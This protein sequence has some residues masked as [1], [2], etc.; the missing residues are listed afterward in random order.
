MPESYKDVVAQCID[1]KNGDCP[2][3]CELH[4]TSLIMTRRNRPNYMLGREADVEH[5]KRKCEKSSFFV[6]EST[7]AIALDKA[8]VD[9]GDRI[10]LDRASAYLK[11]GFRV[12]SPVPHGFVDSVARVVTRNGNYLYFV[13]S[14]YLSM[15]VGL[16]EN[17]NEPF[18]G[19]FATYEVEIE[20]RAIMSPGK[21]SPI[22][23]AWKFSAS[24]SF[25]RVERSFTVN[26]GSGG[27]QNEE[28]FLNG[29]NASTVD[30]ED[31]RAILTTTTEILRGNT[32]FKP[33]V[34]WIANNAPEAGL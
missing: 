2:K 20:R 10:V 8:Q 34:T 33:K 1:P 22:K 29:F 31:T 27:D 15:S 18:A 32:A 23:E 19:G 24:S 9:P 6:P 14:S 26:P 7:I 17:G 21:N 11:Q 5:L 13:R 4:L 28:S 16:S 30:L 3:T 12:A 25:P